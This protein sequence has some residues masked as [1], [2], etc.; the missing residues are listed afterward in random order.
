MEF[1]R[2]L[3]IYNYLSD[4]RYPE[5]C[6]T[7]QQK[8]RIRNLARRYL[9]EDGRLFLKEKNKQPGPEVLHE[10]NIEEVIAKVHSEGHFG[11]NNTWRRIRLQYEGHKLY[12]KVREY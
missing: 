4:K 12:D 9:A 11:V 8:K 6:N 7:E 5:G 10:V 2:Y 1:A 3:A